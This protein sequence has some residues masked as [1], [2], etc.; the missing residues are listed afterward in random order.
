MRTPS[1]CALRL[2]ALLKK[3]AAHFKE[4]AARGNQSKAMR[5][6]RRKGGEAPRTGD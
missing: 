1:N 6:M 5:F 2:P 3:T 4:R